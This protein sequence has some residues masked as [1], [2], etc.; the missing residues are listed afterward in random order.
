LFIKINVQE[1]DAVKWNL[2]KVL[3]FHNNVE[4]VVLLVKIKK[5]YQC[6]IKKYLSKRNGSCIKRNCFKQLYNFR[7]KYWRKLRSSSIKTITCKKPKITKVIKCFFKKVGVAC[8]KRK[9][10]VSLFFGS[11]LKS[12]KCRSLRSTC[13]LKKRLRC[14]RK[15]TKNGCSHLQ[16]IYEYLRNG[17]LV[18]RSNIIR[19]THHH[20]PI[21]SKKK[22]AKHILQNQEDV[23]SKDV[24]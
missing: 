12:K 17:K 9:C 21:L 24:V 10:C 1:K 19:K 14:E 15:Y 13:P 18:S 23:N 11:V 2:K 3:K 22:I 6:K 16:C 8:R 4:I 7:N 20:C 5:K